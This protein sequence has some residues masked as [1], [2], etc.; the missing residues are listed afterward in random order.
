MA[1]LKVTPCWEHYAAMLLPAP[2]HFR[3]CAKRDEKPTSWLAVP[4]TRSR[5]LQGKRKRDS[6]EM[7]ERRGNLYENKESL[8]KTRDRNGN[9]YENKATYPPKA[10]ILLKTKE[11]SK[12]LMVL[13][14]SR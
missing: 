5:S 13:K 3:E 14:G 4:Q 6:L 1:V 10:G 8:W 7:H 9:V 2:T 12:W 11:V